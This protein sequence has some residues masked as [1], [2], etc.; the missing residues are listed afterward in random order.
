MSLF[1][2]SVNASITGH[3]Q[4]NER[5]NALYAPSNDTPNTQFL[6]QMTK[7]TQSYETKN[8]LDSQMLKAFKE[9]PYTHSLN[10]VA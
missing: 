10:S 7:Q 9:N 3:E 8:E 4:S 5:G 2:G 1:N 6:G